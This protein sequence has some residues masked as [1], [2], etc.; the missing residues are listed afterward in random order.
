MAE[1]SRG[2]EFV[3]VQTR[4]SGVFLQPHLQR[5]ILCK[6]EFRAEYR[7]W[8]VTISHVKHYRVTRPQTAR[9]ERMSGHTHKTEKEEVVLSTA[10]DAS[11]ISTSEDLLRI[12]TLGE[13]G[14]LRLLLHEEVLEPV[15]REYVR[16]RALVTK[17]IETLEDTLK[18][19]VKQQHPIVE[20]VTIDREI[21]STPAPYWDGDTYVVP[22]VQEEIV[23][24]R[25]LVLREEVRIRVESASEVF[26]VPTSIRREVVDVVEVEDGTRDQA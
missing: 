11:P 12:A 6:A 14:E 2:G 17:R 3:T 18:L 21:E 10:A 9:R 7:F 8:Q 19:D 4:S 24:T 25:R 16:G 5:A 15:L 26:E 20:R 23:V 13:R 22:V 1:L